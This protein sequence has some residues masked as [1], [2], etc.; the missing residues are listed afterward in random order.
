MGEMMTEEQIA[1]IRKVL[2]RATKLFNTSDKMIE[3]L[4]TPRG[5]E[6]KTPFEMLANGDYNSASFFAMS[7]IRTRPIAAWVK[8]PDAPLDLDKIDE[9]FG[10]KDDVG[11]SFWLE[12]FIDD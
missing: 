10:Y 7:S 2:E 5:I 4:L 11:L 9:E 6:R 8:N 12:C 3:Y 1:E